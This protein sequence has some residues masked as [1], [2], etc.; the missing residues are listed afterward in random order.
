MCQNTEES[1][2]NQAVFTT[3]HPPTP[4]KKKT[5]LKDDADVCPYFRIISPVFSFSTDDMFEFHHFTVSLLLQRPSAA[6]LI[7]T[8]QGTVTKSL[9]PE[10]QFVHLAGS[11][12]LHQTRVLDWTRGTGLGGGTGSVIV[13]H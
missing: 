1:S 12:Q 10:Q 9:P 8:L 3:I 2:V 11:C 13:R 4:P 6:K 7:S 5:A